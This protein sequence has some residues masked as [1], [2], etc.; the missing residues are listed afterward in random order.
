MY[1]YK[2]LKYKRKYIN[3]KNQNAGKINSQSIFSKII[4]IGYE[5]E[6]SGVY[7]L[8]INET[9]RKL[10]NIPTKLSGKSGIVID[11]NK[12][13][14]PELFSSPNILS[15]NIIF[16]VG[17]DEGKTVHFTEQVD[18]NDLTIELNDKIYLSDIKPKLK[19]SHLEIAVTY[20]KIL[21][22][23][24]IIEKTYLNCIELIKKFISTNEQA[25]KFNIFDKFGEKLDIHSNAY[26]Y[27]KNDTTN[28][29]EIALFIL[30]GF[31]PNLNSLFFVPQCTI[32]IKMENVIDLMLT[33]ENLQVKQYVI[34]EK[35]II[36]CE[37]QVYYKEQL[38][39]S[40][41]EEMK[42]CGYTTKNNKIGEYDILLDL[43]KHIEKI[44]KNIPDMNINKK[45]FLFLSAYRYKNFL[46]YMSVNE[47]GTN[48]G[49]SL[50]KNYCNIYIRHR[51]HIKHE[52]YDNT[53]INPF[54][55]MLD[56]ASIIERYGI[57]KKLNFYVKF[58]GYIRHLQTSDLIL[59]YE[60]DDE[61]TL[62]NFV[63]DIVFLEIRNFAQQ[64]YL[65]EYPRYISAEKKI[66]G[67]E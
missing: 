26:L 27:L 21:Q 25:T 58:S 34:N 53:T 18:E 66:L 54:Y 4:S 59:D 49:E 46:N 44:C 41:Y 2:Y 35:D 10:E 61:S 60:I 23:K 45:T 12:F 37:G 56:I 55:N 6:I 28:L 47:A 19:M 9:S 8:I 3:L 17:D 62:F 29:H 51:Y 20:T 15:S 65:R 38:D 39:E 63:D 48:L 36:G 22:S 33:L 42:N 5:V 16:E 50:Y 67:F 32:A 57:S 31:E 1:Y 14:T 11:I 64:L 43:K 7:P 52:S 13:S 40:V 30:G 24:D